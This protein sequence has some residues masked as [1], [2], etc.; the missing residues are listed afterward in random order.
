MDLLLTHCRTAF[1]EHGNMFFVFFLGGLT[2]SLTHCLTMCGPVVACQAACASACGNKLSTASQ[3]QYHIGRLI[4][5]G[6]LG[7][8]ASLFSKQVA[9]YDFWPNVVSAMLITAGILFI[10]SGIFPTKHRLFVTTPKNALLRGAIM[11]FMPCGLLYAAVMM[12]ATIPHPLGG[13]LAMWCFVLGTMPALL[14]TS[15]GVMVLAQKWQLMM[16]RAG[17][18]GL[19]FNGLTL[20]AMAA[21]MVRE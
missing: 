16:G 8:V 5:Y 9:A 13:M 21:R 1:L 19:T 20:L 2:G 3:W 11:G 4:T 15:S 12:A 10:G 6:G 18:I 17:R 7:F 14:A